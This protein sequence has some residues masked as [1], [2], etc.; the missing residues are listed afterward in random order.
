MKD[1]MQQAINKLYVAADLLDEATKLMNKYLD[2]I[3]FNKVDKALEDYD[4]INK[5]SAKL[6]V[7]K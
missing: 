5:K 6:K 2:K 3:S 4:R 1:E 7:I